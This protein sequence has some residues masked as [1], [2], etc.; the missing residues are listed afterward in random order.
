MIAQRLRELATATRRQVL[1]KRSPAIA[2]QNR[3]RCR[4]RIAAGMRQDADRLERVLLVLEGLADDHDAGSCPPVLAGIN[5]RAQVEELI[6][7]WRKEPP[8]PDTDAGARLARAGIVD[9]VTYIEARTFALGYLR[10]KSA[11]QI[12]RERIRD[13]EADL[14]GAK[15]DGFWPTPAPVIARMLELADIRPGDKVLEPSAGN[16]AILDALRDAGVERSR[17]WGLEIVPQLLA[18]CREKGHRA[19]GLDFLQCSA[20]YDRI[21]MNPPFE[22]GQD[23]E[24][25]M[26]AHSLLRPGGRLVSVVCESCFFRTEEKYARL[27]TFL[28]KTAFVETL[29][30][31]SFDTPG[32]F[33]RTGVSARLVAI[34][35]I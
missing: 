15:I 11:E 14:I 1:A 24:H 9:S 31:G 21:V 33:R 12:Q 35:K 4:E 26:H 29:P 20:K 6:A 28:A 5:N 10:P 32:A 25:I 13:M 19:E 8:S 34:D 7:E 16:G 3:T 18:I 30:A 17:V 27:R 22:R 23:A 2:N